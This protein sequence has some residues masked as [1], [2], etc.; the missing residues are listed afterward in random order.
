MSQ[1]LDVTENLLT[2]LPGELSSLKDLRELR[3]ETNCLSEIP[4]RV[5]SLLTALTVIDVIYQDVTG[6]KIS[7]P[8]LPILHPGLAYLDLMQFT[9][10][11]AISRFH[12]H[13]AVD[14]GAGMALLRAICGVLPSAV[15]DDT[16][17]ENI[18]DFLPAAFNRIEILSMNESEFINQ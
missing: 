11:D 10:W 8:L 16:S 4:V 13:Q 5:L 7:S 12:I 18:H 9:P 6:F 1:K 3:M 15:L 14:K 17:V 2:H